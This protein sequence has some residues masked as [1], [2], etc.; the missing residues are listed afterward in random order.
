M[1]V[2]DKKM[3][4]NDQ[5]K[6]YYIK[7]I[8]LWTSNPATSKTPFKFLPQLYETSLLLVLLLPNNTKAGK[9]K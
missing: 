2:S 5:L 8:S 6:F 7:E 3:L 4:K 9:W 1:S